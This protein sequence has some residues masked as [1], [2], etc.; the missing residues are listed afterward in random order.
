[1]IDEMVKEYQLRGSILCDRS[2]ELCREACNSM[3]F[4]TFTRNMIKAGVWPPPISLY[5]DITFTSVMQSIRNMKFLALCDAQSHRHTSVITGF[6][7]QPYAHG[8]KDALEGML[9]PLENLLQGLNIEDYP[10]KDPKRK[11]EE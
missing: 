3:L 2:D 10:G 9:K 11:F 1:M 5:N 7:N 6:A 4:G 8:L